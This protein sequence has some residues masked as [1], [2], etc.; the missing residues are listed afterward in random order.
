MRKGS[1]TTYDIQYH[2]VLVT[3]YRYKVLRPPISYRLREII[4]QVCEKNRLIIIS[5]NIRQD[6]VHVLISSPTTMSPAAIAQLIK[7]RSSKMLQ[8]EFPELKKRYRGQHMWATGYFCKTVGTVT[9]DVI[10]AYIE[11]QDDKTLEEIFK[12][13]V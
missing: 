10:K 13:E 11:N 12:V 6:H 1:H 3:K 4:R 8:E 2:F 9:E 7:G 5:G